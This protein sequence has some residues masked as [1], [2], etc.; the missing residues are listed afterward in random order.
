MEEIK[1]KY[2]KKFEKRMQENLFMDSLEKVQRIKRKIDH[3]IV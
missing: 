3:S 2:I 1:N